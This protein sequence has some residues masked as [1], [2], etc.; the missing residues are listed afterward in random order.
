MADSQIKL[1][2]EK[3]NSLRELT[4]TRLIGIESRIS[5][6]SKHNKEQD[7]ETKAIGA[8]KN[9]VAGALLL[10]GVII[11]GTAWFFY[12][13]VVDKIEILVEDRTDQLLISS[14]LKDKVISIVD[15]EFFE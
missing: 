1:V 10:L 12:D 11:P 14:K 15:S 2:L 3:I 5:S 6:M 7:A 9:R 13:G 8:W 4:E